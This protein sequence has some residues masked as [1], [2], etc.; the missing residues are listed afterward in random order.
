M[1]APVG[2]VGFTGGD[3][4]LVCPVEPHVEFDMA[5]LGGGPWR[6]AV[7][8]D[9]TLEAMSDHPVVVT[10]IVRRKADALGDLGATWLV[11]LPDLIA[12]LERRWSVRVAEPLAG[13]TAAYVAQARTRDGL[14]VVLKLGLPDPQ[15]ADE[16]GTIA[17]AQ[18]RGYVQLLAHDAGRHAMLLE[19]L[20]PSMPTLDMAP[21]AQLETLC[22]LLRQ[23]WDV[24]R[25]VTGRHASAM[26]KASALNEFLGRFSADSERPC[27]ERVLAQAQLFARRRAAAFDPE[28]CVVVH[29]DAAA[30]NV[31]QVLAP[32][33]GAET[34]FVFVD[35]D[36]FIGDPAYD[37]GV[38]L[39]DWCPQL[40]ASNDPLSLARRYCRLLADGSGVDEQAIWE[41]GY[42][43]RVTTGLYVWALGGD[44]SRHH[45]DTAELLI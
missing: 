35:P 11:G 31:L 18:G 24:P 4:L 27:S 5:G 39:R 10:P 32:R 3:G 7:S 40:L 16:V 45:L 19:A 43:E 25:A 9:G 1:R 26:D 28:H 21:E 2:G 33:A 29:G 20:G 44:Q 15:F 36:G 23:A 6:R 17:R 13:G 41:W 38:A 34:G 22:R 42:L 37:L 8:R 30:A 14:D 12:D